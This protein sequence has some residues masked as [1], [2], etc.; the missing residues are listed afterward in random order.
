MPTGGTSQ[1]KPTPRKK[2]ASDGT[3]VPVPVEKAGSVTGSGGI[4]KEIGRSGLA[5]Y[6]GQVREEFLPQLQG[7][8]ARRVF[9][10]MSEND[11]VI[12]GMLFAIEMLIRQIEWN[13]EPA[14]DSVEAQVEADFVESCFHDMSSSWEA[15]LS[16]ILSMLPYGWAFFEIVYKKRQGDQPESDSPNAIPASRF[17]DGRI[18]WRK[19]AQRVQTSLVRWAFDDSG[20]IQGM[21]QAASGVGDV[22]TIPIGKALLFRT[23][24]AKNNPEGRSVLR[25][26]YRPWWYKR[27]IEEIE[28]IGIE[29]DLAGIPVAWVPPNYLADDASPEEVALLDYIKNIVRDIK[30]DDQEGLVWPLAFDD[31]GNKIYDITLLTTG[32][33]RQFDTDATIG[34][35]NQNI[36]MTILEDFLLLGHEKVGSFAL[37]TSKVQLFSIAIGAW[38]DEI[39]SVF[40]DYGIPRLMRI[41]GVAPAL[42][43]HLTHSQVDE[44]DVS[45]IAD[46]AQK[47]AAAGLLMPTGDP[48]TEN[49]VRTMLGLPA[50]QQTDAEM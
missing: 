41:N 27:R 3:L 22:V 39:L 36:A 23:T 5:T 14:D 7:W 25:N 19:L 34:R 28:A 11:P 37:G 42:W 4:T 10:E 2:A 1:R 13:A 30:R 21:V 26:A 20:G 35:L 6:G 8:R 31:N 18:G 17:E 50:V 45:K 38:A 47:F 15:T 9:Q 33:R 24:A 46:A 49:A 16:S 12:G 40:N 43:P 32:G 44:V 48:D 29:R